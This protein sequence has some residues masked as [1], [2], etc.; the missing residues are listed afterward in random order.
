MN[1]S[2][3]SQ[4]IFLLS[5]IGIVSLII[6]LFLKGLLPLVG[7]NIAFISWLTIGILNSD[8]DT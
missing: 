3:R 1:S 7:I 4:L 2:Q 6:S 5:L 8:F